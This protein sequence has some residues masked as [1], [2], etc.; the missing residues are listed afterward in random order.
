MAVEAITMRQ[1]L[2]GGL[3][4]ATLLAWSAKLDTQE[5]ASKN[6]EWP[7]YGGDKGFRKY[8]PLDQINKSNVGSLTVAWRR[9]AVADEVRAKYPDLRSSNSFESTR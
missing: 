6:G 1:W 3:L 4:C 7:A 2:F 5:G 9:S 8:S